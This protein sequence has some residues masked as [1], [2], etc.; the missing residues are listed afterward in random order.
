MKFG[1]KQVTSKRLALNSSSRKITTKLLVWMF[2]GVLLVAVIASITVGFAGFGMIKGIIDNA[3]EVDDISIAPSGYYTV[4]YNSEGKQT[5]KLLKSG[6]NRESV[7]IDQIPECL[8]NAFVD[9]EDERFYEHDGIDVKGIIRAGF[10]AL[11]TRSLSQGASTITQQLLKNNVF[12]DGGREDSIGALIKRKIQ[13]QYLALQLEKSFDKKI[14]LENYLNTI[15]LGSDTL[16]VQ[17]ASKRYFNKG[18]AKLTISE[19]AVLA[20]ITQ[21]PSK[22]NPVLHPENNAERREKVLNNMRKNGHIT[23][24][25]YEEAINDDVYSRI[26]STN[27]KTSVTNPYSYFVDALIDEVMEDLQEQKGYTETQAYNALYSGGLSIYTT[28]DSEI[29]KICDNEINNPENYPANV[30]YSISWNYSVKHKD[31]TIDNYSEVNI[32]YFN[33][34]TLDN[35][36]FK[37]LFSSTEEADQYVQAFKDEFVK[38]G[39]TVLGENIQYTLQPQASFTVIDQATGYVKAIVGGRGEKT[40]SRTL[41]RAV[42]TPRQ[43]G[44]C[45]K[46]LSTYAPAI[47]NAGYTLASVIDD[48]PFADVNGRLVSNWYKN[49]Y[50][51]LSTLR[52]G[53]RDSMNVVTVKLL[54]EITPQ[55]GFDYLT[56]FGFTTLVE[57]EETENGTYSDINQSLALG[58]VTYG[59][60]NLELCAAYASIANGG[61]YNSPVLYTKVLDHNG[62]VILESETE[63]HTVLKDSSAWLLTSAMHDVVTSGTGTLANVPN[64]Y[65]AGKTG[66]TTDDNDIWFAGY[67]PYLTAAIWSGYDEN[68][69]LPSTSYHN[70][71]WSKIMTQIDEVKGYQ[72]KEIEMPDSIEQAQVCSLSGKLPVK[73]VC[74]KDP[75]GSQII[76]E[77]FA[78]GTVPTDDCDAHVKLTICDKSGKIATSSCPHTTK[79]VYRLRPEG[80]D[81]SQVTADTPYLAPESL[82]RS[83][84]RLHK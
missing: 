23:E 42:S 66:T 74:T 19:S 71:L 79:V 77:Y 70:T 51:G 28:Q 68:G 30:S 29:Q 47:D 7:T 35:S 5:T 80:S 45:F 52:E 82:L 57:S 48:A 6:S 38:K 64:M 58:G 31:G 33:R 25:E 54:T 41:N 81:L 62:N 24:A 18:V 60:T 12:E 13:E 76:T 21:N 2:K 37:M 39:D 26:Q 69:T 78:K 27:V 32:D 36:K 3:P 63:S 46:V 53:I 49:G 56:N 55:L 67:T 75:A 73:G 34:V 11:S 50:R 9:I 61:V 44:S 40:A 43:P 1:M 15:N 4:V 72:N 14:I 20:A 83:K 84:C 59:V 16:G 17:A 8:Q 65:V 22:Y 10:I